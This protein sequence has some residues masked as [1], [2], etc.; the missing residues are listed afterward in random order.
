VRLGV[1]GLAVL[2]AG[3]ASPQTPPSF[4]AQAELVTVDVVVLGPGGKPVSGLTRDD[5]VV[6]EDGR[7]QK[8]TAF[9]AVEALVPELAA[10][11]TVASSPSRARVVTNVAGPPT[12]RTFAIVFDDLHVGDLNIENAK[13]AVET[14][15]KRETGAGDRVVLATVSDAR[16]WAT[17]RGGE[18]AAWREALS[19][20]RSHKP[21]RGR[22]ECEPTY[23]EA[24]QIELN[25]TWVQSLFGR[26]IAALC[27]PPT[28]RPS[29]EQLAAGTADVPSAA[30]IVGPS[31]SEAYSRY[32]AQLTGTLRI[33]REII[34]KLGAARGRKALVLVTEGFP[35]DTS[36]DVFRE[37]REQAA[38]ANVAIHFLDARGLAAGPEF[39]SAAGSTG[40]IPGRDIGPTMAMWK[41]EDAGSKALADETGGLVLQTNDLVSGLMRLADESRVTY[42]LGY[43]PTNEK[44]DGRYRKLKVEVRRLG[45]RVRARAGYFASK[46]GEQPT[47][48]PRPVERAMSELFDSEAIPLRLAAYVMGPAAPPPHPVPRC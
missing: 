37:V 17:T 14:F 6:K 20:V 43:E 33:L 7:P 35:A 27:V 30:R 29:P 5:F 47:P 2:I 3:R 45:L 40:L 23:Y 32:R 25:N 24:M 4:A 46:G 48:K 39:L 22:S 11:E 38:R 28:M 8:L 12:R 15:V 16:F 18:D 9:E 13:K 26:R 42:L 1:I 21:L 36:L 19:C 41:L 34:V 10:P 31:A 44:R